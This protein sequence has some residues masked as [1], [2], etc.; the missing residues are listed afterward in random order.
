VR[1]S[2]ADLSDYLDV[3]QATLSQATSNGHKCRGY[4]VR[5]WAVYD[6]AGRVA[7]YDVPS[8][9]VKSSDGLQA[10]TDGLAFQLPELSPSGREN[11]SDGSVDASTSVSLLP[12]GQDYFRPVSSGGGAHVL[13]RAVAHDNGTARGALM[14][15]GVVIGGL[16]GWEI[17]DGHPLG[18]LLG[19]L[20]GGGAGWV[21]LGST[22]AGED[23][24]EPA[25]LGGHSQTRLPVQRV[26]DRSSE[27]KRG[28]VRLVGT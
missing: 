20:I 10:E 27:A 5:A 17:G 13:A 12:Q 11:P 4:P 1:L 28:A 7:G 23:R 9:V 25:G 3:A 21:G 6:G 2:Q 15:A 26:Q 16:A 19:A 18:G 8:R 24:A 14:I 22:G